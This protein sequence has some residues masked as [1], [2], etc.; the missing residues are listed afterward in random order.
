TLEALHPGRIDLGLGRAPGTDP[1]TT[2]ALRR[3]PSS[4][5]TFPDDVLELQGYLTD[6]TRV[7]GVNATPGRGSNVPLYILGSSLFGARLAATLGLPYA[8]ASHFAP[9]SLLDAIA[10]Y[11]AEF[12]PSADLDKPYVIAGVNVC[13]AD[14]SEQARDQFQVIRRAR[15]VNLFGRRLGLPQDL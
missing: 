14:T 1:T 3:D 6:R 2:R 9:D 11:H 8:F 7:P 12:K 15:A 5:D 10:N 4:A 13:A